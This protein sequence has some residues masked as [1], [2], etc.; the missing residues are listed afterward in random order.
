MDCSTPGFPV[1]HQL[2]ELTL[3]HVPPVG[4]A[5][6]PP[7][8]HPP[9]PP[10]LLTPTFLSISLLQWVTSSHQVNT[11]YVAIIS[12]RIHSH[13][14]I[15]SHTVGEITSEAHY[16]LTEPGFRP[17]SLR[18]QSPSCFQKTSFLC[19]PVMQS[20]KLKVPVGKQANYL[21][22]FPSP[23]HLSFFLLSSLPSSSLPAFLASFL[24]CYCFLNSTYHRQHFFHLPSLM[25]PLENKSYMINGIA[26]SLN[27]C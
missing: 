21:F 18:C 22:F 9:R 25:L 6:Q 2:P 20:H 10:F 1:H 8:P 5:I 11:Y 26:F 24:S 15:F 7:H 27:N 16:K 14:L 12:F 23:R 3:T 13:P 19:S 4:D 17:E